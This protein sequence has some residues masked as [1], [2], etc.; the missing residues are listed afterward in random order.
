MMAFV[1]WGCVYGCCLLVAFVRGLAA[2]PL[3]PHFCSC[4]FTLLPQALPLTERKR[5]GI[6][7]ETTACSLLHEKR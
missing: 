4:S 7:K 1:R 2:I 6:K 5:D 3:L